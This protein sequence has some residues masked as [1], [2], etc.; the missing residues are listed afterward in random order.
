MAT[1]N[2]DVAVKQSDPHLGNRLDPFRTAGNV[3]LAECLVT[4]PAG[5]AATDIINLIKLPSRAKVVP[6]LSK[7]VA[8]NPGT[9]LIIDVGDS[10]DADRYIDGLDISAGGTFDWTGGD[11]GLN[12]FVLTEEGWI[13]VTVATATSLT[14]G[15]E[16]RFHIAYAINN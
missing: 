10:E 8:E 11:A 9:A 6:H 3:I 14:T 1:F 4:I 7:L 16:I 13:A 2:S 5:L 15:Q 12:P